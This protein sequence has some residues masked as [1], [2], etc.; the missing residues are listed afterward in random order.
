MRKQILI[1]RDKMANPLAYIDRE[2]IAQE[3][4]G[5]VLRY[6]PKEIANFEQ[7]INILNGILAERKS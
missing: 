6:W 2:L 5:L 4:D 1:H 3:L 7:Q